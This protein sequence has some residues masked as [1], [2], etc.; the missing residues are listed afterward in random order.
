M[1]Q[2]VRVLERRKKPQHLC[3]RN[4]ISIFSI[5]RSARRD[6]HGGI[7]GIMP[8]SQ[9]VATQL[10][11]PTRRKTRH[12]PRTFLTAAKGAWQSRAIAS[13]FAASGL[14]FA[15]AAH[16]SR[17]HLPVRCGEFL[18]AEFRQWTELLT[19]LREMTLLKLKL[20]VI[21][22]LFTVMSVAHAMT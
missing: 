13:P 17:R 22:F 5:V 20:K 10:T 21:F 7:Q 4:Q 15:I 19:G 1:Q 18:D 14:S 6:S 16:A 9:T 3:T 12:R 2:L 11:A 8:L